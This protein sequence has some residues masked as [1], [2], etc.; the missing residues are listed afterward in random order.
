MVLPVPSALAAPA[1]IT[2]PARAALTAPVGEQNGGWHRFALGSF[3]ITVVSD[4][5]L[6]LVD[7]DRDGLNEIIVSFASF[8]DPLIDQLAP[9]G[10]LVIPVGRYFQKLMLIEKDEDGLVKRKTIAA[11]ASVTIAT[12]GDGTAF[13]NRGSP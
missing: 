4:G 1:L 10:R 12:S 3:A 8:A 9:N 5:N 7:L 11:V 2:V 13:V 6:Q